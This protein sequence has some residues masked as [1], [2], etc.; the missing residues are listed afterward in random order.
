MTAGEVTQ[1]VRCP[2]AIL[3][4]PGDG[5]EAFKAAGPG[6]YMLVNRG[7]YKGNDHDTIDLWIRDPRGREG[8]CA[9]GVHTFTMEDDG[10][11]TVSPSIAPNDTNPG[12][13]H[14]FLEHG[15]W[16]EV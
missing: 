2:D 1:G 11:I 12:G 6:A 9:A 5:W 13:W 4:E 10:T 16:R 8:R 7:R 3:G 14:G 15:V